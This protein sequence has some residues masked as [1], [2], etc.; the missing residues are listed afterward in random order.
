M[1]REKQY[2]TPKEVHAK[3]GITPSNLKKYR[4]SGYLK[5]IKW[6]VNKGKPYYEI[7]E[8]KKIF[9]K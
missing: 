3:Y 8:V 6:S 4:L 2:L 7:G 9:H 1:K 5:D